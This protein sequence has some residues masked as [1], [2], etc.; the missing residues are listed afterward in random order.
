LTP[1]ERGGNRLFK[2]KKNP[3]FKAG[4]LRVKMK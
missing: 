4:F 1:K 2:N 3:A